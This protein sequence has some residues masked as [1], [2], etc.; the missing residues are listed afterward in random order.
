MFVMARSPAVRR[1]DSTLPRPAGRI[2]DP[3]DGA[4]PWT[5]AEIGSEKILYA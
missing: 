3:T 1:V 5:P 2:L 4:R